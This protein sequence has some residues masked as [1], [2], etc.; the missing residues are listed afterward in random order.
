MWKIIYNLA[1]NFTDDNLAIQTRRSER[2]GLE[3]RI[4]NVIRTASV[5]VRSLK[6]SSFIVHGPRLFNSLPKDVRNFEGSLNALENKL[7]KFLRTV[8]DKPALPHYVQSSA[9]NSLLDQLAQQ[10]ADQMS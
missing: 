1:P 10:R 5:R 6:E 8:P 7:D 2:R 3:C 4:P 9:S